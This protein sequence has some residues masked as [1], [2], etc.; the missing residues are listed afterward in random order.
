MTTK[1]LNGLFL[2]KSKYFKIIAFFLI[3]SCTIFVKNER[4]EGWTLS[5]LQGVS[6]K[7]YSGEKVDKLR[8]RTENKK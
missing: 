1:I 5:H 6:K 3:L 4:E 2:K 7:V 8:T